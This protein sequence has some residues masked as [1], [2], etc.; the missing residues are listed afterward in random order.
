MNPQ[1]PLQLWVQNDPILQLRPEQNFNGKVGFIL[2][3]IVT[4]WDGKVLTGERKEVDIMV[5]KNYL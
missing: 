5:S 3:P 2:T 1:T 4:G